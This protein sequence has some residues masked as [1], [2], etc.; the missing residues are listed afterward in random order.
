MKKAVIFLAMT[1]VTVLVYGQENKDQIFNKETNL[2]EVTDY[3]DNGIISQ[4]GT[5]NVKGELHGEWISY[6]AMGNKISQGSYE[7]GDKTG[8]WIFWSNNTMKEVE[9]SNNQIASING[10]KNSS[11][12]ADNH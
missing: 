11:R 5:F 10:V 1:F 12:V 2:I 9:Y 7:N 3:H 6:D 8:K 4:E